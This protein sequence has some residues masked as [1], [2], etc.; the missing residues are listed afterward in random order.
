M[1][2]KLMY[3]PNDYKQNYHCRLQFL[4]ETFDTQLNVKPNQ[5]SIKVPKVDKQTNKKTLL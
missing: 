4:V 2:D 5:N 3:I 1:T